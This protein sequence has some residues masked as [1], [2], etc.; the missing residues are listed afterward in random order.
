MRATLVVCAL[1]IVAAIVALAWQV[2]TRER[3]IVQLE[4]ALAQAHATAESLE[5]ELD[6]CLE[7]QRRG[8]EQVD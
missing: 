7:E 4:C 8:N 1:V 6:R 3:R 5:V 2:D